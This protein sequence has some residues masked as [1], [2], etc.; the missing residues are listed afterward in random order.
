MPYSHSFGQ[1]FLF[2]KIQLPVFL[3]MGMGIRIEKPKGQIFSNWSQKRTETNSVKSKWSWNHNWKYQGAHVYLWE[4]SNH[5]PGYGAADPN[6][7]TFYHL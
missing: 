2:P 4:P 5:V 3:E 7:I 1:S 6:F